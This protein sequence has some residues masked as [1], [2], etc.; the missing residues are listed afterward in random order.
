MKFIDVFAGLGGFHAGIG[1]LGHE[2]VFACEINENLAT[3]YEKNFSIPIHMD[4]REIK[5][6]EIPAHDILCAGFPCQPF[7]KAGKQKGR[8][9]E[10]NGTLFDELASI[11]EYH[12]PE[13]FILENVPNIKYHNEGKTWDHIIDVLQNQLSYEVDEK[14]LSPHHVGVP[15]RRERLFIVGRKGSLGHFKWPDNSDAQNVH[16]S[17]ILDINPSDAKKVPVRESKCIAVW[18]E[19]LD[20]LPE[21]AKLPSFPIWAMEFGATYPYK[22][23]TPY[24]CSSKELDNYLGAFGCSLFDMPKREKLER[25]PKYARQAT[26][27][28]P[29]WKQN[30]ISQNREF[31]LNYKQ[32]ID[33]ILPE[34]MKFPPSWQKFEWNCQGEER[35]IRNFVLQF[36]ASGLRVKRPN[37]SPS[38]ISF[39][40]THIPIIGW[41]NRYMTIKEGSRLQSLDEFVMPPTE[42]A[43]FKALGNAVN[44]KIVSL[45]AKNLIQENKT[46]TVG[47]ELPITVPNKLY[48]ENRINI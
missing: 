36:R 20:R 42:S 24:K 45:I 3:L 7:S 11:L 14:V 43:A 46:K 48:S 30:F 34:I 2:C 15:Q 37:Y 31:Y 21:N 10:E 26:S 28:F 35:N 19:F 47:I 5:A 39:S 40:S 41:E 25:I 27:E 16:I 4:I 9:D 32:Q 29:K 13:Y 6:N 33:P 22:D 1:G 17:Q 44:A 23:K 38:L 18:Q 12:K 8:K